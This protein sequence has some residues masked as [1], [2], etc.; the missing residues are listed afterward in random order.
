MKVVRWLLLG[1]FVVVLSV[2]AFPQWVKAYGRDFGDFYPGVIQ[3]TPEG[4]YVAC[5]HYSDV[6]DQ[7][8]P[9]AWGW[10]LKL[11]PSGSV[12]WARSYTQLLFW[13]VPTDE[14]GYAAC[15]WN[16]I[17]KLDD[18]GEIE[19]K[20]E[21][22]KGY[23]WSIEQTSDRG[24]I[25]S[26][27]YGGGPLSGETGS[28]I[29]K[30]SAE[31]EVE[32]RR[33]FGIGD[34]RKILSIKPTPDGGYAAVGNTS[35]KKDGQGLWIMKI[36]SRG[37]IEWQQVLEQKAQNWAV[38]FAVTAGGDFLAAGYRADY[39]SDLAQKT[40]IMK[41]GFD[42]EVLWQKYF[43]GPHNPYFKQICAT[44][45]GGS[46]LV[47]LASLY[48]FDFHILKLDTA[49]AVEWEKTFGNSGDNAGLWE[50]RVY[51]VCQGWDGTYTV[52]GTTDNL[53]F[54]PEPSGRAHTFLVALNLTEDGA[55]PTC[56]YLD[57]SL[58]SNEEEIGFIMNPL[59]FSFRDWKMN[60]IDTG[61]QVGDLDLK[62]VDE[63]CAW[64]PD[65]GGPLPKIVK[66]KKGPIR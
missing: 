61:I 45:D 5:G 21:V 39:S 37:R 6:R 60:H 11:S 42:G 12:E 15:G 48:D 32:W 52:L 19:W 33:E 24:Y 40:W 14:G 46:I 49:G 58:A 63:L 2:P 56:P 54:T 8:N 25:V 30:L 64:E 57:D 38:D 62:A 27:E 22:R 31:G 36:N 13:I 50:D 51:S 16:G 65:S 28:R 10:V 43:G 23:F 1:I 17:Y 47:S 4:G 34:H 9:R 59:T 29:L 55:L 44:R 26:G 66:R 3:P 7:S 35:F 41:I 53:G 20:L 18:R